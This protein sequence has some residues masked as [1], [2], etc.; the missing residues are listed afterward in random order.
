MDALSIPILNTLPERAKAL[1]HRTIIERVH[2]YV[3]QFVNTTGCNVV[4][5]GGV[6]DH[7]HIQTILV[8]RRVQTI[9][10]IIRRRMR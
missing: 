6:N 4:R 9:L 2:C 3:G 5:V 1:R 7:V 10:V 8:S